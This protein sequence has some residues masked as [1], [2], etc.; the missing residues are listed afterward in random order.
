MALTNKV[1]KF[2]AFTLLLLFGLFSA[3]KLSAASP[4]KIDQL[5][6]EYLQ[7]PLGIDTKTPRFS[8]T[9]SSSR[10]N[11]F[12]SAYEIIVST[13]LEEIQKLKGNVWTSGKTNSNQNTHIEYKGSPLKSFTKYYWRILVYDEKGE[14]SAWSTIN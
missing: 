6:C 1:E 9:M 8:W 4:L 13:K 3:C 10:R 5:S 7:N 11:Q 14:P 12:Q 2:F